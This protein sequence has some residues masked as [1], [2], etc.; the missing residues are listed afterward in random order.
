MS[1]TLTP[2]P[3]AQ[4][5]NIISAYW[6]SSCVYV[7]AKLN[8][9]ALLSEGPMTSA[10][11]AKA[12]ETHEPSLFRMLRALSSAGVF[13]ETAP[14]TFANT[15]LSETL[16]SGVP[17]SM[18]AMAI[19]QLGDH[20]RAW[21]NLLFSIKTGGIAFDET[22]GMDIWAYYNSHPAEGVNFMEAMTGLTQ[23]VAHAL[24]G[25][26]DFKGLRTIVDV[27]GGNGALLTSVLKMAPDAKG[28][29]FDEPYVVE[30]TKKRL[31]EQGFSD[32]CSVAGGSFFESMPKGA[33]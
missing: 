5:M 32:R 8:I 3:P 28:I 18:R 15:P 14:R 17:G 20:F 4:M 12:T 19:A 30:E 33:D 7:A 21:S 24:S 10:Q 25:S 2:P 23:A 29:V 1:A 26:Y 27:G 13:Q 9:A 31:A 22:E 16:R 6:T 11:I